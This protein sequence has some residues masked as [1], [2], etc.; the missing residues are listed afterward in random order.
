MFEY[1][2]ADPA[3]FQLL[4]LLPLLAALAWW[5]ARRSRQL[6]SARLTPA[7]YAF[8]TRSVSG[9]R[10]KLKVTLQ[11]LAALLFIF[12]LARPQSGEGRH[13]AK[14]EGLEIM[15]AVDV[16]NSMSAEDVRPSRL[17]LAKKELTRLMDA[18][19]GDRVGLIAFAGSS[20]VLSP[21]TSDKAAI[22]MYLEGLSPGTVST[23]GTDFKKAIQEAFNALYRG[24]VESDENQKMTKVIVIAS[25]GEET[26]KG[27]LDAAR[28]A[29]ADGARIFT[30]GFGTEEGA[31]IPVRDDRGN[32][33]GYKKDKN[34]Q[35]VVTRMT[36]QA[37]Q[38]IAAAG[39]GIY[40]AVSFGG[41]SVRNL[42][43][44]IDRLQRTQLDTLE[45][46]HYTEHYQVLL[47]VGILL[48]LAELGFGERRSEGRGWRGRFEV[49][50]D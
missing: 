20:I 33:V 10:R 48:A 5:S 18:L 6:L 42:K 25:D 19:G 50:R 17:D 36:G 38:E 39:E 45:V 24:G 49:P 26:S 8:L 46:S 22:K 13:T 32:M 15:L 44:A 41:D 11:V 37:L 3:A 12:A 14:S 23:Q 47:L 43:A 35:P 31:Q 2:F 34:G 29:A 28:K 40:Q 30:L 4:A 9:G 1:R 21:L 16:S 27:G 7:V